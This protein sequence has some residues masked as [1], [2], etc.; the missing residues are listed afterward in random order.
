MAVKFFFQRQGFMH[1]FRLSWPV[2]DYWKYQNF[3]IL[4]LSH[5]PV[6]HQMF[7]CVGSIFLEYNSKQSWHEIS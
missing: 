3:K 7:L 4:S 6:K 2:Q 5:S 1:K